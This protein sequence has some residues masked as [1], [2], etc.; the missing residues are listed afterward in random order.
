MVGRSI[1]GALNYNEQKVSE[2]KANFL[3]AEGFLLDNEKLSISDKL[4]VFGQRTEL[5]ERAKS[6]C[7]HI[8]INFDKKD[9]LNQSELR[10]LCDQ[11]MSLIGFEGQPYLVY[12]HLDAAHKHLHVVT[13]N[14]KCDG[15]QIPMYNIGKTKSMKACRALEKEY[16][17]VD[18]ADKKAS[19]THT[20]EPLAVH[21]I[22]GKNATKA[23]ISN[24][25]RA[26]V[27]DYMFTS[28]PELNA[29]LKRFNIEAYRGEPGTRMYEK[30]GLSYSILDK[31]GQKIGIPIK[32]STIYSKPT[33]K[34]LS[35]C[36][37]QNKQKRKA[38]KVPL[39]KVI[40]EA[41]SLNLPDKQSLQKELNKQKVEVVYRANDQMV[42]GITFI[43][44]ARKTVFNGSDLGKDYTAKRILDRLGMSGMA[45]R[46]KQ[47]QETEN[48]QREIDEMD[49]SGGI[50]PVLE[51]IYQVGLRLMINSDSAD[52]KFQKQYIFQDR[53]TAIK[54]PASEKLNAYFRVNKVTQS[55]CRN[56]NAFTLENRSGLLYN[57]INGLLAAGEVTHFGHT[58]ADKKK[59]KRKINW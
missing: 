56:L 40:D 54:I 33:L 12:E 32:A 19:E 44:H 5:N 10:S 37:E 7:V 48:I 57:Y 45:E 59:P 35:I 39:Q 50:V 58:T 49:Y 4:F 29:I 28:L 20:L 36:F 43:D 38:L 46:I 34:K 3:Y 23:A 9:H 31:D 55:V 30:Q 53:A 11:Y 8:S 41:L 51:R 17:L 14:I 47:K 42:Y 18:A 16:G 1:K 27:R 26:I 24:T 15:T 52:G 22:Y 2:G 21:T 25:A 6:N 13:T